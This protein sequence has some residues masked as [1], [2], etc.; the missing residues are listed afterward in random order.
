MPKA[1]GGCRP[2]PQQE[3]DEPKPFE[4]VA[5]LPGL[6][7]AVLWVVRSSVLVNLLRMPVH[8]V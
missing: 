3:A 8:V 2:L 6:G 5:L 7:V 4:D 1:C